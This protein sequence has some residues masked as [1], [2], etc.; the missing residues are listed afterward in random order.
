MD[1]HVTPMSYGDGTPLPDGLRRALLYACP[2]G[3]D[4][5]FR[6]LRA[7]L[8]RRDDGYLDVE[9]RLRVTPEHCVGSSVWDVKIVYEPQD[10]TAAAPDA[11]QEQYD[12]LALMIAAWVQEWWDTRKLLPGDSAEQVED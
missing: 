10:A 4:P 11:G 9:L 8:T 7:R 6:P 3:R 5:Q 1:L 12:W 2:P